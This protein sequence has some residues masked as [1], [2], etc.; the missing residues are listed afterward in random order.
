MP[1]PKMAKPPLDPAVRAFNEA[2]RARLRELRG[3]AGLSQEQL[4][5]LIG[6]PWA[7]Y[8]HMEG[9]RASRFPPHKLEKLSWALRKSCHYILTGREFREAAA[10]Q[11]TRAA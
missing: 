7:N 3:K 8:K 4:C 2:F 6:I 9:K 10:E 5:E 11:D 1:S